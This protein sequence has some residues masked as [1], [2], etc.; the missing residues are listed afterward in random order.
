MKKSS[1][2]YELVERELVVRARR[3][4]V[5]ETDDVG[6]AVVVG[7]VVVVD[8]PLDQPIHEASSRSKAWRDTSLAMISYHATR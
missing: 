7:V 6:L 1:A 4:V 2:A 3:E 8:H 5:V